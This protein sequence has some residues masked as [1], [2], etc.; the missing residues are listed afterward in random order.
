MVISEMVRMPLATNIFVDPCLVCL[1]MK[2]DNSCEDKG[3]KIFLLL[4]SF[5]KAD[6]LL[7]I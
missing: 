6:A 1:T 7:I 2:T 3:L 4:L 5:V